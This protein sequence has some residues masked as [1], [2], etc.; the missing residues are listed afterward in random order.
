MKFVQ[1]LNP[2]PDQILL[3]LNTC[4]VTAS[5]PVDRSG[6]AVFSPEPPRAAR[7]SGQSLVSAE[8]SSSLLDLALSFLMSDP[9]F[10]GC[11]GRFGGDPPFFLFQTGFEQGMHLPDNFRLVAQL[12]PVYLRPYLDIAVSLDAGG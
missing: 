8:F 5:N 2:V 7:L 10:P 11:G 9:A 4:E 6:F 12:C 3:T 1:N